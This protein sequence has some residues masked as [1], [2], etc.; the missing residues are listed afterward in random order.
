[1]NEWSCYACF[2][3]RS[4]HRKVHQVQF[5]HAHM[6]VSVD[7]LLAALDGDGEDGVRPGAV[8][9]HIGSADR[10]C[11]NKE[12]TSYQN[13]SMSKIYKACMHFTVYTEKC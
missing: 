13:P 8:L 5:A 11:R 4:A 10:T 3:A 12:N 6:L 1:M 2:Q 7:A 9:V